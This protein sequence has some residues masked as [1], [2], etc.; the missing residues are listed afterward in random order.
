MPLGKVKEISECNWYIF[1]ISGKSLLPFNWYRRLWG[2]YQ[3]IQYSCEGYHDNKLLRKKQ[4]SSY[5]GRKTISERKH[6]W[7]LVDLSNFRLYVYGEQ[8]H[9]IWLHKHASPLLPYY[10]EYKP[11]AFIE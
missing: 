3:G 8:N 10:P 9:H 1:D 2:I 4:T 11:R 7:F 6:L 5:R